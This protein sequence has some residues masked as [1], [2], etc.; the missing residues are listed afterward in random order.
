MVLYRLQLLL[1]L[2]ISPASI[3][4]TPWL[5]PP[6]LCVDVCVSAVLPCSVCLC[7]RVRVY[8]VLPGWHGVQQ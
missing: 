5:Q 4:G 3:K 6:A 7:M 2:C 1:H 8:V